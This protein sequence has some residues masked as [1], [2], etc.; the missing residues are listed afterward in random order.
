[1]KSR[2]KDNKKINVGNVVTRL[3][4][5][6]ASILVV[7]PI[8]WAFATSFKTN[9]EFLTS[10]WKLP[11]GL[12]WENYTNALVKGHMGSY[13]INSIGITIIAI[14]VLLALAVPA[15]YALSRF[16]FKFNKL[17]SLVFMGGLFVSGSYTVVPLFTLMNKMHLLN[18]RLMLAI[19]YSVTTLPFNIYL[20]SGFFKG[21]SKE[22][23]AAASIDGCGYFRTLYSVIVPMAKPGMVT[24]LM[25][26]FM[27]YWNEYI[28]AFTMIR[29][30][31]KKTLS[32]GLKNLMEVQ[33]YAT[34]WG[35]MFAGLV[36]VMLPT[37]IFYM[38]VQKKLTGGLSLGGLKG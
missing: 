34:D 2:S 5:I 35:A 27:S 20:L 25:F 8:F 28:L 12:H 11:S 15:A 23:E 10:P 38:A 21:I 30:D 31:T 9:R 33:K 29:D 18:N 19:L 1:M 32:V 17:I 36:L 26:A 13:F 14:V 22:Y 3:I 24:V 37:M 6:I 4:L 7:Y 16:D